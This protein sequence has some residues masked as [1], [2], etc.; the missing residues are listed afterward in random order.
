M[1]HRRY[2]ALL[3]RNPLFL[4][5]LPLFSA[6]GAL[7][8]KTTCISPGLE[9]GGLSSPLLDVI[10]EHP[11]LFQK[12]DT[13]GNHHIVGDFLS[14]CSCKFSPLFQQ[15]NQLGKG[16]GGVVGPHHLDCVLFKVDLVNQ[17]VAGEQMFQHGECR[18][19]SESHQLVHQ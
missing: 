4:R 8:E 15:F 14:S 10:A 7:G 19:L 18:H 13:F 2:F 11:R 3:R 5:L 9:V 17:S 16:L 1:V 6:H 12:S